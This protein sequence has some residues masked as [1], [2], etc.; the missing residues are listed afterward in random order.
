MLDES[1]GKLRTCRFPNARSVSSFLA[2]RTAQPHNRSPPGH[3]KTPFQIDMIRVHIMRILP[4]KLI[5]VHALSGSLLNRRKL[6]F[7]L[8]R[9]TVANPKR[10]FFDPHCHLG[11]LS[12]N[13][14]VGVHGERGLA[15]F[16]GNLTEN[17]PLKVAPKICA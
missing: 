3:R 2:S 13:R 5:D 12:F 15:Q 17:P 14:F 1:A 4:T 10:K 11:S 16:F 6:G 7:G 9:E 8:M